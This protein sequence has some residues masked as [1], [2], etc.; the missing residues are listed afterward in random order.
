DQFPEIRDAVASLPVSSALLDGEAAIVLPD[1]RTSFQALQNRFSKAAR[2]GATYFAF[3]LLHLDGRD[4]SQLPLEQRKAELKAVLARSADPV[5]RYSQHFDVD[6]PDFFRH[7]CGV[8]AEGIVSKR[9]DAKYSPTRADTWLKTKCVQR[10]AF[11]IGGFTRPEGS[12]VGI[13]A[14]LLGY[15]DEA[16]KLVFAGKVGTGKGFTATYLAEVRRGLDTIVQEGC[17]YSVPPP[18]AL[19]KGV[20]WV[21]PLLVAE[22]TFAEWTS[23]GSIRHASFQGFRPDKSAADVRGEG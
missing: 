16:G 7:A 22:V 12:R 11:V 18:A 10:R 4:L 20:T 2:I 14:L 21:R 9:R 1:G 5:L 13:G 23:D 6:G 19:V 8:G 15:Y 3:D 17:P